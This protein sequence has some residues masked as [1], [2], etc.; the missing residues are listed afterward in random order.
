MTG[1]TTSPIVFS[2]IQPS[3][4]LMIGNYPGAIRHWVAGQG[5]ISGRSPV[6][7]HRLSVHGPLYTGQPTER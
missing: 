5:H 4:P 6:Y 7:P 2:G 3:G 1:Q